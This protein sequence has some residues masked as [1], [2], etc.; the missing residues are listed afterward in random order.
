MRVNRVIV[1]DAAGT[2]LC[3]L[4]A[5]LTSGQSR[6]KKDYRENYLWEGHA[7]HERFVLPTV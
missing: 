3:I 4:S 7:P 2:A 1:Y 6:Q 5:L